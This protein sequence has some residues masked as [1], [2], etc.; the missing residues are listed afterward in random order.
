MKLKFLTP[1]L[2]LL[3]I[4]AMTPA[5]AN[6]ISSSDPS[7]VLR[8]DPDVAGRDGFTPSQNNQIGTIDAFDLRNSTISF[9]LKLNSIQSGWNSI[10]HV[11]NSNGERQPA[12]WMYPSSDRL[13]HRMSSNG[14]WN[15]GT[16]PVVRVP[17]GE[18]LKVSTVWNGGAGSVYFFDTLVASVTLDLSWSAS[19]TGTWNVYAG[20]PW[21]SAV[22]GKLDDIRIYNRALSL[23]ELS[24]NDQFT[25]SVDEPLPLLLMVGG[26]FVVFLRRARR[27]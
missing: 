7:L 20:D 8:Y 25:A 18:W 21:Y 19:D 6:L 9:W 22:D 27:N 26:L 13:H 10:L 24:A 11:G 2:V 16:D 23:Q 12:F 4:I 14:N 5:Q 1:V 3:S 17:I 15:S